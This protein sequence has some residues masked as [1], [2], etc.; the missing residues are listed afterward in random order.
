M[1][2]FAC[3]HCGEEHVWDQF[4]VRNEVWEQTGVPRVG[5]RLHIHCLEELLGRPLE[6]KDFTHAAMNTLIWF[7]YEMAK[8]EAQ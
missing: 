7:G 3:D 5:G 4:W 6:A 1:E 2:R 8:S